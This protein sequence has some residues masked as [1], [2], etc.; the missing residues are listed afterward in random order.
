[1]CGRS[2][3]KKLARLSML[4]IQDM[5]VLREK[6]IN[7]CKRGVMAE[8]PS[9]HEYDR[10]EVPLVCRASSG[11]H[12]SEP[13]PRHAHPTAQ[14]LYAL[15]GMMEV[16]TARGRWIVPPSRCVWLPI[17][18]WH[19]VRMLNK[20]SFRS[21][22]IRKD[23]L[24]GLPETCCVLAVSPLLRELI[25]S[26]VLLPK[27]YLPDSRADH[28]VKLILDE[29]ATLPVLPLSLP[30]PD[31]PLLKDVCNRLLHQ[32]DNPLTVKEW[33]AELA[34]D[35]RTLQRRFLKETGLSM[36]MWRRQ[37][38]LMLALE[39]LA[40]G[41][42]VIDVAMEMGYANPGAFATMF[43]KELGIA[44]SSLFAKS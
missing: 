24:Q 27:E 19:E 14:L 37:A 10:G 36:G 16:N 39:R 32:P 15:E 22:F 23:Y 40:S 6:V 9:V 4:S 3:W 42:K 25:I 7:F 13:L 38:R 33:S 1:M 41:R 26:S 29:I 11:S 43:R 35:S 17:G 31:S 2:G 8:I 34:M 12:T 20:V 44:P 28:I 30:Y 5:T 21:V 18:T